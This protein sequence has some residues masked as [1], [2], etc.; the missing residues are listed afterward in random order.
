M[1]YPTKYPVKENDIRRGNESP[2]LGAHSFPCGISVPSLGIAPRDSIK[3]ALELIAAAAGAGLKYQGTWNAATNTPTL[4]SG[5]GIQGDYYVVSVSGN[6]NLDGITDWVVGDWAVFNGTAWEKADHTDVVSSVFGRQGAVIAVL[7][8]YAASLV[9]NDSSVPGAT[10][11]DALDNLLNYTPDIITTDLNFAVSDTETATIA[12]GRQ[13]R[14]IL[15]G[16]MYITSD[17]GP[18]NQWATIT[19]YNK[20]AQKGED[21]A[22]RV[23]G[24]QVYTE[25]QVATTGAD[26]NII[27]DS[28][29]GFAPHDLIFFQ[30]PPE[31]ARLESVGATMVAEDNVLVHA[32]NSGLSRVSEFGGACLYNL[33]GGTDIYLKVSFKTAQTVNIRLELLLGR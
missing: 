15:R 24:R 22:Y 26:A 23:L 19:F 2:S 13:T 27:P 18:F 29:V 9:T 8:D 3:E 11:A 17:P 10:V 28:Y 31:F 4:T 14:E 7:G 20:V 16:R 32:I 5:V 1:T 25:L 30:T 21:V 33:E 12:L 6:T